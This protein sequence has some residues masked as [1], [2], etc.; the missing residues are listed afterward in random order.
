VTKS[1][2][3]LGFGSQA[4]A[5]CKN[6]ILEGWDLSVMLRQTSPSFA[7]AQQ[8]NFK[9][10]KMEQSEFPETKAV[11]L[12]APDHLHLEILKD[13]APKLSIGT[14]I[15]LA[16]GY[17]YAAFDLPG[18]FPNLKF[19]LLAPK[20][21]ASELHGRKLSKKSLAAV[22]DASDDDQ[23][24]K[25]LFSL[26]KDLGITYQVKASC[27]EET[28][29]DLFSEQ[30]ILCSLLPYGAK[31]AFDHLIEKGINPELAFIECWME[32]KLIADAMVEKGPEAFFQLISPNALI[33]SSKARDQLLGSHYQKNL[34]QLYSDIED[35]N[36]YKQCQSISVDEHRR[37]VLDEWKDSQ[38]QKTY[39]KLSELVSEKDRRS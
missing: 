20:A 11:A 4:Q 2:T 33:G 38:L 6:L 19:A 34:H 3:I 26:M 31:L 14:V 24:E 8:L 10:I 5:W 9:I 17:S 25:M 22:W 35:G 1:L 7:F 15:I 27:E 30:T 37:I 29:A 13:L 36:F 18:L 39:N 12:L 16:H 23:V 28:K 32:L 21:I